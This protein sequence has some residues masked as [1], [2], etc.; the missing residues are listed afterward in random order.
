MRRLFSLQTALHLDAEDQMST[1][2]KSDVDKNEEEAFEARKTGSFLFII[3]L[4]FNHL[5]SLPN[6]ERHLVLVARQRDGPTWS[7]IASLFSDTK[8]ISPAP[9]PPFVNP[10]LSLDPLYRPLACAPKLGRRS[11]SEVCVS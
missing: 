4:Y 2:R 10:P 7:G 5:Y 1:D 6:D 9:P 11:C 8:E 3:L